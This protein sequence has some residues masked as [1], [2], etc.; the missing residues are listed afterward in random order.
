MARL[1]IEDSIWNDPRYWQLEQK[2]GK[3]GASQLFVFWKTAQAYWSNGKK[4]VP[5]KAFRLAG[6]SEEIINCEL[7]ERRPDGIYAKGAKKHFQWYFDS[8]EKRK[9][10]GRIGGIKSAEKRLEKHGSA[11][12]MNASNSVKTH[13]EEMAEANPKQTEANSSKPKQTEANSS[14][15]KVSSSSSSSS[16]EKNKEKNSYFVRG[17]T[18]EATS[19]AN[20]LALATPKPPRIIPDEHLGKKT[21]T[22]IATYV[23]AYQQRYGKNAKP[24][25][26]GKT[27]GQFKT[28][29]KDI[30]SERLCQLIEVYLQMEDPWFVKKGHDVNT[31]LTNIQKIALALDTGDEQGVARYKSI[32]DILNEEKKGVLVYDGI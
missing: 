14:K 11:V 18:T 7:A 2:L 15:P 29:A 4:L 30:P 17:N 28:L 6:F 8:A 19:E 13:I 24:Q 20:Q 1:N 10:A 16:S 12:P 32:K 27:A 26:I 9:T 31:L 23:K 5:E 25:I 21:S 3:L 22:A